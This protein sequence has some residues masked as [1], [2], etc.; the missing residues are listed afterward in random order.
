MSVSATEVKKL[1]DKT[2]AGMMDCKKALVETNGEI[3]KAIE[4]LRK[5]GIASAQKRAGRQATEGAIMTYLHPGNRIGVMV[6]VNCETDFVA[7]TDNFIALVKNIAMQIAATNPIAITRK[8]V[9]QDL[10]DKEMDIFK[11]QALKDKKPP[12]CNFSIPK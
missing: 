6:E 11:E 4:Y 8:A 10:V 3:E 2:G 9:P 7:K 1:R 5:N 12:G